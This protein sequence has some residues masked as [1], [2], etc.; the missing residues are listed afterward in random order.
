MVNHF[1]RERAL[2]IK[3]E[4]LA[5]N[6]GGKPSDQRAFVQMSVQDVGLETPRGA[7]DTR[8]EKEIESQFVP[9]RTHFV[10]HTPRN[11]HG[12]FNLKIRQSASAR[13]GD[14]ANAVS[15]IL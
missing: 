5:K 13:I 12:A 2:K 7:Q 10:I 3:D 1:A 9:R 8:G 14:D 6:F 11:G 15:E 4:R